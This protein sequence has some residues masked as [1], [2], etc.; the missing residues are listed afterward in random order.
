MH[1]LLWEHCKYFSFKFAS[2]W[3]DFFFAEFD[4]FY[5]RNKNLIWC[6]QKTVLKSILNHQ[7]G[8]IVF[9][10]SFFLYFFHHFV[11]WNFILGFLFHFGFFFN[12]Y[13]FFSSF[14][15]IVFSSSDPID[16]LQEK[17]TRILHHFSILF[18][19]KNVFFYQ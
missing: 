18:I 13:G 8:E 11:F 17:H 3:T 16:G 12:R 2:C 5:Q 7:F 10:S 14:F 15:S 6:P 4:K 9:F 19:K 1:L